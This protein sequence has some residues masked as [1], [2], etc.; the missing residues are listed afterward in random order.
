MVFMCSEYRS[1]RAP[2]ILLLC[3][4]LLTPA[5]VRGGAT[6]DDRVTVV[7]GAYPFR[8]VVERVGAADVRLVDAV[9]P[10]AEP[11]DVELTPAQVA[12]IERADLVVLFS[13]FQPSLEDA[14][15][16]NRVADARTLVPGDDPH[17]WLDP[18][19]LGLLADAVAE[20]LG[21]ADP[22]HRDGYAARAAALEA[23]LDA[24][25][26]EAEAALRGCARRDLVT[27]HAAWGRFADRYGLRATGIAGMDDEAEPAPGRLADVAALVRRT[28]TTTVFAE[29]ADDR[30]ARTVA[31]EAG[32]SIAVLD[33]VEVHRNDDY[34]AVMR[35]NV[36]VIATGLGCR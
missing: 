14:A 31:R 20:R 10:G 17:V 13:G 32:V 27:S 4:A 30:T 21:V 33:P 6:G 25:H 19:A 35:R 2:V 12:E 15:P 1:V 22:A 29:S 7:T 16:P 18:L 11:H 36:S 23:D 3:G 5:C 26:A 34:L 9:P 24:L 28:G 8:Y